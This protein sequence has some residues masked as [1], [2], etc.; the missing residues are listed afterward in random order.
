MRGNVRARDGAI[1]FLSRRVPYLRLEYL[2]VRLDAARCKLYANG[3][4]AFEV[5]LVA[6]EPIEEIRF[7]DARVANEHH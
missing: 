2:V 1:T 5:K 4:L 7:P 3:G 6:R